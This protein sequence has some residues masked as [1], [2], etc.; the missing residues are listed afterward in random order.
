MARRAAVFGLA[1]AEAWDQ[2]EQV[3]RE[4]EQWI[5]RSAATAVLEEMAQREKS[6]GVAPPPQIEQLPW[7]ISWAAA[8]GEGIGVG[9]AA[10][11]VLQR[12]LSAADPPIR[13]AAAQALSQVGR[14]KDVE[15][16]RTALGDTDPAVAEAAL[17]ALGEISRRYDLRIEP[18][19]PR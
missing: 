18:T 13:L 15:A 5:V 8:Q 12:A 16:L 3:A 9:D 6:P 2:L 4:D 1:Q 7:L 14:P 17:D 10:L 11:Q 19:K